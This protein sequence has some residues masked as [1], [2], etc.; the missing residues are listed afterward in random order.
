MSIPNVETCKRSHC[1]FGF[2][3][4][5]FY[6]PEKLRESLERAIKEGKQSD[7]YFRKSY[8]NA[9]KLTKLYE[10]FLSLLDKG[11]F[12]EA[13]EGLYNSIVEND[14]NKEPSYLRHNFYLTKLG[15]VCIYKPCCR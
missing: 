5:E 6:S 10:G 8:P 2:P 11:E 15:T 3:Q 7:S 9:E 12:I 4:F 13:I 14:K 1:A